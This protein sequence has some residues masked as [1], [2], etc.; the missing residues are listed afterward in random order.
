[1]AYTVNMVYTVDKGLRGLS[2]TGVTKEARGK[3]GRG[4]QRR[5]EADKK[6]EEDEGDEGADRTDV[7]AIYESFSDVSSMVCQQNSDAL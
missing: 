7:A 5:G 6:A 4:K 1:M 3:R 2:G